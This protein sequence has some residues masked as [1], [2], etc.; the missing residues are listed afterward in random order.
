M[1][2]FSKKAKVAVSAASAGVATLLIY[3]A[4]VKYF[5]TMTFDYFIAFAVMTALAPSGALHYIEKQWK[6]SIE[7]R[8]PDLLRDIAQAQRTGLTLIGA[9]EAVSERGYGPLSK[10]IKKAVRQI[11][12]GATLEQAM[13]SLANRVNTP[14]V[15][16]VCAQ[17]VEVARYGGD[18]AR[19]MDMTARFITEFQS[20]AD[21]RSAAMRTYA[22]V[23][24]I[25][26]L[27]FIVVVVVIVN[28]FF[29]PISQFEQPAIPG[30]IMTFAVPYITYKRLFYHMAIIQ[31][32]FGG[33]IA[34]KLA[35]GTV[36][37]G[38][39]HV[40]ILTAVATIAFMMFVK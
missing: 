23:V 2:L 35:E 24:Y 34:G 33:L 11:S 28:N 7:R 40:V 29:Y 1:P 14:L 37:G 16:R 27:A 26:A 10:E 20:M 30:T 4:Y 5:W 36:L 38:L 31:S 39:K 8:L 12:W 19:L 21:E 9:L 22:G 32:V 15:R 18:V 13:H 25:G 6:K 17:I 3:Y